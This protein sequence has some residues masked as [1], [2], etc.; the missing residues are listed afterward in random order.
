MRTHHGRVLVLALVVALAACAPAPGTT[1]TTA[2]VEPPAASVASPS[3]SE[4]AG[5]FTTAA[6]TDI[7][8]DPVSE[9][10]AA[11]FQAILS[12][13]AG[14]GGITATVMTDNGTWSGA[15]GKA[16][17]VRDMR[18]DDQLAIGSITKSV[19]AAQVMQ[20]VEAGALALDD[21]ASDQVP[22]DLDFD[23]NEA[24]IRQLM[25]MR[26][27]IPDYV[28]ALWASLSTDQQRS[29]TT[30]EVLELAADF[31]SP[32]GGAYRYSSTNY[33]LLGLIVEQVRGRPLSD[34]L[35]D[36][37]LSG[38]GL[39]RLVFQPDEA[40]TKPM[41]MPNGQSNSA[42]E[43]G[44]GYLPSLAAATAA[45]PAGAMASDSASLARW[46]SR[47]CGGELVSEASVT[48]MTTSS[49]VV[50]L[51]EAVTDKYGLG[52]VDGTK[53]H[54]TPAVGH[55]GIQVGYTA[56]AMCFVEEGFVVV[57]LTNREDRGVIEV[58]DALAVAARS[59]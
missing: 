42:L 20:L 8:E 27:G 21:P 58:A 22:K 2:S 3:S 30:A 13:M 34:V 9:E 17:G 1:D 48:E 28:D 37:V 51:D 56:W 47:F 16:D 55:G 35:R 31:R 10:A 38:D 14:G 49:W 12:D 54:G 18:V 36:G 19:I 15:M 46:W 39:E 25:G 5:A 44:G 24:T 26:S 53:A 45:G 50:V 23:T 52:L 43:A 6:F 57:V 41:A 4:W 29:W 40:P 32:A 11:K 7:R 59:D 33:V